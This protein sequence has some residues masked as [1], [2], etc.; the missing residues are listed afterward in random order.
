MPP[1]RPVPPRSTLPA[2]LAAALAGDKRL[3]LLVVRRGRRRI[4]NAA[5][6]LR[7]C[8]A[9]VAAVALAGAA[10]RL[11]CVQIDFDGLPLA[12]VAALLGRAAVL[13]GVHGAGLANAVLLGPSAPLSASASPSFSSSPSRAAA[14]ASSVIEIMPFRL[15]ECEWARDHYVQLCAALGLHH[16]RLLASRFVDLS[17]SLEH[18]K[19]R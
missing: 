2:P 5:A 15:E 9:I 18:M 13:A 10:A 1:L 16:K 3:V 6:L 17:A 19:Q 4:L 7:T 11:E 14:V 12:V 8:H